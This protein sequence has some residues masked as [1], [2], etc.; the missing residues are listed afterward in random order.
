VASA[1]GQQVAAQPAGNQ[2]P[3]F[4]GYTPPALAGYGNDGSSAATGGSVPSGVDTSNSW[5]PVDHT[6]T[7]LPAPVTAAPATPV[8][9]GGGDHVIIQTDLT[10]GVSTID[11]PAGKDLDVDVDITYH[12]QHYE[13][14]VD[15]DADAGATAAGR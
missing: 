12:G 10:T 13:Q 4:T 15:I 7:T 8:P 9:T 5:I 11:A 3:S 14:H 6:A 2:A 1:T